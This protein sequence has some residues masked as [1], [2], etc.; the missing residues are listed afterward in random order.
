MMTA[1]DMLGLEE[2]ITVSHSLMSPMLSSKQ[3]NE[4]LRWFRGLRKSLPFRIL[5]A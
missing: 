3:A 5:D 1:V 4:Y 2:S